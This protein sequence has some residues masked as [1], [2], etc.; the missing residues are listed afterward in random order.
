[1]V[2]LK[3]KMAPVK[4]GWM[5]FTL[6]DQGCVHDC[7][8]PLGVITQVELL[9]RD[10][11]ENLK[12]QWGC[13]KPIFVVKFSSEIKLDTRLDHSY[14]LSLTMSPNSM[15]GKSLGSVWQ[16]EYLASKIEVAYIKGDIP[17]GKNIYYIHAKYGRK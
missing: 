11:C 13:E 1:M 2:V 5:V 3:Q 6:T 17:K 14:T 4:E 12:I 8:T 16:L 9:S 10:W 7:V 15:E